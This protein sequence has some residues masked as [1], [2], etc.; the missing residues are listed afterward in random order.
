MHL[1]IRRF[2]PSDRDSVCELF[3]VGIKEHIGPCFYNA[4]SSRLYITITTSLCAAGYCL[5]S[6][7][8]AVLLPGLWISVVYYCCYE[9]Y[10]GYVRNRLRTDMRDIPGCFMSRPGDCFWVAEAEMEGHAQILGTVA[11]V[12]RED[13]GERFGE[14]FRMIIAPTCRRM[15]LGRRLTQTVVD[16][17]KEGGFSKVVL[18]TSST[19]AA[20]VALYEKMGFKVVL[21]HKKTEAAFWITLLSQITV[22]RMEK[23][24]V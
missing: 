20:A 18:E 8:G 4:M 22:I 12:E 14:L 2:H 7:L 21:V 9:I 6:W 11:V 23:C 16:F 17:C 15:G 24:I 13:G 1:I 3:S 19:Q 10:A 5:G